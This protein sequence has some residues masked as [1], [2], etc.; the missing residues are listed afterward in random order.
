MLIRVL[1]SFILFVSIIVYV[2]ACK[3]DFDRKLPA[4]YLENKGRSSWQKPS[5]VI[6][7]LGDISDKTVADIGAGSGFFSFRLALKAKKVLAIDIDADMIDLINMQL[8]NLPADI[9]SKVE[10][11]LTKPSDPGFKANEA[12]IVVIINTIAYIAQLEDY[13]NLVY[14]RL[15][16]GGEIVVIDFKQGVLDIP[17]P[18]MEERL[19][20]NMLKRLLT[21]SGFSLKDADTTTLDYQYIVIAQK[22]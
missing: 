14:Q 17:S 1:K 3:S 2:S 4:Q 5:V 19:D 18:P 15:D 9:N 6:A 12:D 22:L 20:M 11:R 7:K 16:K 13:L 10:T 8:N 21:E